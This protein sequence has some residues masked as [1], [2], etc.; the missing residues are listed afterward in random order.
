[1]FGIGMPEMILILIV[2]LIVV[3]P[4]RLPDL[5]KALGRAVGEFRKATSEL[6]ESLGVDEE[7]RE[8][9]KAFDGINSD[10]RDSMRA[11]VSP[12]TL[13]TSR[14]DASAGPKGSSLPKSASPAPALTDLKNSF[15]AMNTSSHGPAGETPTPTSSPNGQTPE[16]DGKDSIQDAQRER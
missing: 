16:A 8:V 14:D 15:D 10:L 3:G 11:A 12:T 9:K 4:K 1:M 13:P 2:A 7:L 6:K 5:A